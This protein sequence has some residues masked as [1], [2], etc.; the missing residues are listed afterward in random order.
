MHELH[1]VSII[2]LALGVDKLLTSRLLL[3]LVVI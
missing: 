2:E 3:L 1:L